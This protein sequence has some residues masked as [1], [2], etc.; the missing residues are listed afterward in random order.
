[1]RHHGGAGTSP[2]VI[3][4]SSRSGLTPQ[5][6]VPK[7]EGLRI[8]WFQRWTDSEFFSAKTGLTP[9]FF[10]SNY[11]VKFS[12]FPNFLTYFP[13]NLKFNHTTIVRINHSKTYVLIVLNDRIPLRSSL[14][15]SWN[16]L[17]RSDRGR[18]GI[19]IN[20]NSAL[21]KLGLGL[22]LAIWIS[23]EF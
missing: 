11:Y 7:V 20:T 9:Y 4:T 16:I 22:S 12:V 6:L 3:Y 8:S 18:S 23:S 10:G 5:N 19:D 1:M 2:P 13:Q 14:C 21:L 17:F 15:K